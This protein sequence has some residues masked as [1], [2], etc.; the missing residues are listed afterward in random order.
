MDTHIR[1]EKMNRAESLDKAWRPGIKGD[2]SLYDEI[3]HSDYE[4]INHGVTINRVVSK[5]VFIGVW[6]WVSIAIMD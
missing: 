3:L 1:R 2:F 5:A 6:K 4:P